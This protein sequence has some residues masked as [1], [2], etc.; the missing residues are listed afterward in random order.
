MTFQIWYVWWKTQEAL[1]QHIKNAIFTVLVN[2]V[3]ALLPSCRV[4]SLSLQHVINPK[5]QL[6]VF[7]ASTDQHRSRRS[8]KR[9]VVTRS[10]LYSRSRSP[11]HH[12]HRAA[13]QFNFSPVQFSSAV[14]NL[15]CCE[16]CRWQ[17]E[18][19]RFNRECLAEGGSEGIS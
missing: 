7:L 1:S 15:L 3:A 14:W 2:S 18:Q 12:T 17:L 19:A 8:P 5:R 6:A 16:I 13:V 10:I 11:A 9:E 4:V